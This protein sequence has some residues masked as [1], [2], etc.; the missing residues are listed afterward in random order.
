MGLGMCSHI[1]QKTIVL[2]MAQIE[3]ITLVGIRLTLKRHIEVS[4]HPT[5]VLHHAHK[6]FCHIGNVEK[7]IAK[8][9]DLSRVY[10]LMIY[11]HLIALP[12]G[13]QHATQ[14]YRIKPSAERYH[15]VYYHTHLFTSI[16]LCRNKIRSPS[17]TQI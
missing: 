8:F 17:S 10:L 5:T 4:F 15:L 13:K 3:Q 2:P 12:F 14:V 6:P 11:R 16:L 1:F 7:H 9:L